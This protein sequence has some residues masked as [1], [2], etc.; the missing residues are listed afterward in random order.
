MSPLIRVAPGVPPGGARG[1]DR[2]WI[3]T[4]DNGRLRQAR[5]AA[6]R[7]QEQLAHESGVSLTTISRLE[8]QVRP[9]C[10]FRTRALIAAVLGV[11][12]LAIT[13]VPDGQPGGQA[14]AATTQAITAAPGDLA[15]EPKRT[16]SRTFPARADQV[17]R[18]RALLGRLLADC[19]LADDAL[20]VCS[21]LACNAVQHSASARPGGTFTVRAEVGASPSSTV[22]RP[23]G[24]SGAMTPAGL[25]APGSTGTDSPDAGASRAPAP[26]PT[27]PSR[28]GL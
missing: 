5:K 2:H 12:A 4:L 28:P 10:H 1:A 6:G 14:T 22:W 18:A 19:P 21:E 27:K 3:V 7:S 26:G 16:C 23:T 15:L 13:A 11:H 8:R 17:R 25:Y 20:L 24:K 9:R